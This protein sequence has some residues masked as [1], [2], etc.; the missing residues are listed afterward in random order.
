MTGELFRLRGKGWRGKVTR[1]QFVTFDRLPNVNEHFKY[2]TRSLLDEMFMPYTS[3]FRPTSLREFFGGYV[4][5]VDANQFYL[6][7]VDE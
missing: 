5:Y 1:Q 4:G 2:W 3:Y 7:K 6:L